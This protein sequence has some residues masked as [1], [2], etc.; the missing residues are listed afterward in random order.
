MVSSLMSELSR[1]KNKG[2]YHSGQIENSGLSWQKV[3]DNSKSERSRRKSSI[4][5]SDFVNDFDQLMLETYGSSKV[6]NQKRNRFF[7]D[8]SDSDQEWTPETE[9]GHK[10]FKFRKVGN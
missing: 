3:Y 1:I 8:D 9:N 4:D 5:R 2:I 10:K 7:I 6:R